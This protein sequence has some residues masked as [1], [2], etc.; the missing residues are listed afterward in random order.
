MIICNF[1][2]FKQ[3]LLNFTL[4]LVTAKF[5]VGL[6]ILFDVVGGLILSS[7]NPLDFHD[8]TFL[9]PALNVL[10]YLYIG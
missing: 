6:T 7:D 3:S 9:L 1:F 5:N 4:I 2:C 8:K 10:K